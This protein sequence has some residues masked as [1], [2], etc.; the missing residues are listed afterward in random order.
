MLQEWARSYFI[1]NCKFCG[2][3]GFYNPEEETTRF[4]NPD[5]DCLCAIDVDLEDVYEARR[6]KNLFR[7]RST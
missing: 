2:A 3:Y 5:E 4:D 1:G 7:T 6:G